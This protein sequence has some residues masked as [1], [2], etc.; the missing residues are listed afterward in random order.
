V[1]SPDHAVFLDGV[2]IP[3][4]YLLNGATLVQAQV[5]RVSY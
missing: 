2:L 1:L 3:I 5:A 4:R